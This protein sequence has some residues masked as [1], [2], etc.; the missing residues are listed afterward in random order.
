MLRS[1]V[2]RSA[3]LLAS[4]FAVACGSAEPGD[5][6]GEG[7][8]QKTEDEFTSNQ[9]SLLDFD[10]DGE[11]VTDSFGSADS[12]I[13]TQLLYTIGHLNEQNSVGRLDKVTL[14]NVVTT[15]IEGGKKKITYHAKL[16]VAWGTKSNFPTTYSFKL[17]KDVTYS[18]QEAFTE[19]YKTKCVDWSAHEVDSSSMWYYYRP[20]ACTLDAADIVTSTAT[21][22]R[23]DENTNGKY[24]EY[25]QVWA[26]NELHVVS[27]FGKYE[28]GKTSNSDAGIAAYNR[29]LAATKTTLQSYGVT[30]EPASVASNP[31]VASPDV[32]F[33]GTLPNG[34]KVVITA[35]LVDSVTNMGAAAA[36]YEALSANAD[37]IA[38]N[39]H[40]GLGQNVRALA[41]MGTWQAGK[42]VIVFMNGCDTFAYVDGSLAK[43]RAELNA[44]DPTGTKYLDFVT[45]AMPSMFA[46]MSNAT[47]TLVKGL[48]R[49]D[50]PMT[51]EQIFEGIDDSQ[52][53]LVTG[54][55]DNAY[56]PGDAPPPVDPPAAWA[57]INEQLTL[58][59]G[60]ERRFETGVLQPGTYELK[61]TG[62]GDADLY[63]KKGARATAS[64]YDCRPYRSD[65]AE[66]CLVNVTTPSDVSVLVRGYKA[67]Q[68]TFTALPKP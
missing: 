41:N 15:A 28:D 34:K 2:T 25:D 27:I 29:F 26:D 62:S 61:I 5:S 18:G 43:T 59:K 33:T 21:I 64:T 13:E 40:A 58:A 1:P 56:T 22:T 36:R 19:K 20:G 63:V 31:G 57:G 46:S 17:P 10:F 68:V 45:N 67:S 39:G 38:Y 66:T 8:G 12:L 60:A 48:L 53:V 42:Y 7:D 32:T 6:S 35:L 51:Y 55:E 16:P 23:S 49:F 11:M 14:T 37:V 47:T 52:F 65:S 24:P 30:S 9:A 4:M 50:T 54:E 44:D 3:L